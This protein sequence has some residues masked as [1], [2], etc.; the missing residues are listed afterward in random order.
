MKYLIVDRI[1]GELVLLEQEDRQ[2]LKVSRGLM[3]SGVHEGNVVYFDGQ[4]WQCDQAATKQRQ[5]EMT[6]LVQEITIQ[7]VI[8]IE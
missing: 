3:A 1:E 2:L 7:K 6:K 5:Q 8:N 4:Y